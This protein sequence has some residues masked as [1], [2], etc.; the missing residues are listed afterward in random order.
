MTPA[1]D[2]RPGAA[3]R[4]ALR[5]LGI[6][7]LTVAELRQRL[8]ARGHAPDAI[9]EVAER[10]ERQG[11]VDDAE[12]ARNYIVSRALRLGHGPRRLIEDLV[13]RGV[14]R[15]TARAAWACAVDRGDLDCE[16]LLRRE[17]E[18]RLG[19]APAELDPRNQRRVY[20]A[21]LRA[22]FEA[23]AVHRALVARRGSGQG[24]DDEFA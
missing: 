2:D 9:D 22:G 20:N 11:Y 15:D 7:P 21:L 4:E 13:R 14:A 18:R 6:R 1:R 16:A 24:L 12:L 23:S 10:V 17:L 8:E 19:P 3:W 5:L